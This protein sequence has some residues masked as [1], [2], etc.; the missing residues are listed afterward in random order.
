VII[1]Q[2]A[3][4]SNQNVT[5][6]VSTLA[7]MLSSMI[8]VRGNHK[9]FLSHPMLK[10]QSLESYLLSDKERERYNDMGET[11]ADGL[12]RLLKNGR[13]EAD[14]IKDYSYSLLSRS[15]LDFLC[16]KRLYEEMNEHYNN[17]TYLLRKANDFYDV[18]VIDLNVELEH[19]LFYQTLKESDVFI[20]VVP[21]NKYLL[22]ELLNVLTKEKDR[23]RQLNL[24]IQLVMHPYNHESAMTLKQLLKPHKIKSPMTINYDTSIIDA[25][26]R[27]QLFDY[28]LRE[29][30]FKGHRRKKCFSQMDDLVDLVMQWCQEVSYV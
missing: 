28:C 22:M 23:L 4:W 30:G 24:H 21:Q 14:S 1:M 16:S 27:S 2:I 3:L 19:P 17:Y 26:N 12:F 6:G 7:V 25:C 11:G 18:S 13:L 5:A 10:D 15:N 9:T 29:A 20:I 8:A